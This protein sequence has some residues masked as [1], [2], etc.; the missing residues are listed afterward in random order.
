MVRRFITDS[1]Y[2]KDLCKRLKLH[3][4]AAS[5]VRDSKRGVENDAHGIGRMPNATTADPSGAD[6]LGQQRSGCRE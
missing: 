5:E 3:R 4:I 6:V 1:A 2:G